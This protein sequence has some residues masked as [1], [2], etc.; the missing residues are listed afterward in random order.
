MAKEHIR[1]FFVRCRGSV[2]QALNSYY[3]QQVSQLKDYIDQSRWD[4]VW[5]NTRAP[6][7]IMAHKN[8]SCGYGNLSHLIALRRRVLCMLAPL[9]SLIVGDSVIFI[10]TS[11]GRVTV[12]IWGRFISYTLFGG[13]WCAIHYMPAP[14]VLF[15]IADGLCALLALVHRLQNS[16]RRC[17]W[18]ALW[19]SSVWH[20]TYLS[21]SLSPNTSESFYL[22]KMVSFFCC[23]RPQQDS[24]ALLFHAREF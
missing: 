21:S 2:C 19:P 10:C 5:W 15:I 8:K 7:E 24:G 13:P 16:N 17:G 20:E 4:T 3:Y 14:S 22:Q 23:T 12:I 18:P 1:S 9:R 11:N 6:P